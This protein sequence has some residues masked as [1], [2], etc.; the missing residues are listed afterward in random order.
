M[1]LFT[2][3]IAAGLVLFVA[4]AAPTVVHA[5][6]GPRPGRWGGADLSVRVTATPRVAQPRHWLSYVVKVRNAGP[7][8]A[9]LPVLTVRVPDA[10]RIA[11]VNVASCRPGTS[12]NE[13]VCS[14]AVDIPAGD[15]GAVTIVGRV[16]G[17]ARGPL[18]AVAGL[19]S[20]VVD[21]NEGDNRAELVTPVDRGA[22]PARR[23]PAA[24]DQPA[25]HT[26]LTA[27]R[28]TGLRP[29][30]ARTRCPRGTASK[31]AKTAKTA[32]ASRRR[33]Q[34]R[35]AGASHPGTAAPVAAGQR[36]T[37]VPVARDR[38]GKRAA[39]GRRGTVVRGQRGMAAQASATMRRRSACSAFHPSSR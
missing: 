39:R 23:R 19:T 30:G 25:R 27:A 12:R 34:G 9:V 35:A 33:T 37:A 1:G 16:K 38:Q 21:G 7:G 18:R 17:D 8:Q 28:L 31:T 36:G 14:S 11:A 20:E 2:A 15:S 5:S 24:R 4:A 26:G 3:G 22:T 13:V 10:V 6:T 29:P 32:G